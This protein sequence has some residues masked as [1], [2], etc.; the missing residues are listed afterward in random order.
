M[1]KN[2]KN[3]TFAM[4][5]IPAANPPNPNTAAISANTKNVSAQLNMILLLGTRFNSLLMQVAKCN[6]I[7]STSSKGQ[8]PCQREKIVIFKIDMRLDG[9]AWSAYYQL[10]RLPTVRFH[11]RDRKTFSTTIYRPQYQICVYTNFGRHGS[12]VAGKLVTVS[13]TQVWRITMRFLVTVAVLGC[14]CFAGYEKSADD[15]AADAVRNATKA[16]GDV[17]RAGSEEAADNLRESTGK[18][19]FGSSTSSTVERKADEI[20]EQ[21]AKTAKEIEKSGERKAD[22]IEANQPK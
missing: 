5:A 3:R 18:D 6:L 20:E 21:G 2:M 4:P 15:H 16:Q 17:V 7:W 1:T 14:L 8:A 13:L 19:A 22:Q 11:F 12:C 9:A 10:A